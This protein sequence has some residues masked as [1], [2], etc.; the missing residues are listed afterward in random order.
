VRHLFRG[1]DGR[2]HFEVI[3]PKTKRRR[4]PAKKKQL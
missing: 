3:V 4:L 2:F 1:P